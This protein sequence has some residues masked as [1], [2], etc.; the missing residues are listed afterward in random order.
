[1]LSNASFDIENNKNRLLFVSFSQ[2]VMSFCLYVVHQ[3]IINC[4][5]FQK[6]E[7]YENTTD[8]SGVFRCKNFKHARQNTEL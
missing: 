1:M 3:S 6:V 7:S 4:N 2:T 5:P 8:M